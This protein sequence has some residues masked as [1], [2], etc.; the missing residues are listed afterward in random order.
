MFRKI[1]WKSPCGERPRLSQSQADTGLPDLL[2]HAP[3]LYIEE[4]QLR[5]LLQRGLPG[6]WRHRGARWEDKGHDCP[7]AGGFREA[8]EGLAITPSKKVIKNVSKKLANKIE[9][10]K[11]IKIYYFLFDLKGDA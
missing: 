5:L 4:H 7:C 11:H 9:N 3:L 10:H 6:A 8:V 1:S 2:L